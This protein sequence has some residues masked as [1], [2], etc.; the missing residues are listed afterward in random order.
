VKH[1]RAINRWSGELRRLCRLAEDASP[2]WARILLVASLGVLLFANRV[3]IPG[4]GT[5]I[6]L[7]LVGVVFAGTAT[8]IARRMIREGRNRK[9]QPAGPG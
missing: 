4:V 8:F 5:A 3:D 7:A 9:S 1:L 6:Y 2:R